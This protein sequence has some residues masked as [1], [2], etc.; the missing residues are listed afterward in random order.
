MRVALPLTF[1][2]ETTCSFDRVT[3]D[4]LPGCGRVYP[5]KTIIETGTGLVVSA[6]DTKFGSTRLWYAQ[7]S[8]TRERPDWTSGSQ[9]GCPSANAGPGVASPCLPARI[10]RYRR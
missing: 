7:M 6:A 3:I 4:H 5:D 8:F 1:A 2:P 9:T 10:G